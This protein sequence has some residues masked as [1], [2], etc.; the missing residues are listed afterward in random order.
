MPQANVTMSVRHPDI[1]DRPSPTARRRSALYA[2]VQGLRRL[3][4]RPE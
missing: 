1:A 2:P 3:L 4:R